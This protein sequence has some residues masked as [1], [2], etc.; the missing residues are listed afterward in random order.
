MAL[1]CC[2]TGCPVLLIGCTAAKSVLNPKN[3]LKAGD[4]INRMKLTS[5]GTNYQPVC[6]IVVESHHFQQLGLE[7]TGF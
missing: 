5:R 7:R 3:L 4:K 1:T 6:L 2:C